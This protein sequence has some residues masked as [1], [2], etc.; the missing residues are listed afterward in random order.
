MNTAEN[1]TVRDELLQILSGFTP[2]GLKEMEFVHLMSRFD[3]KYIFHR[4]QL[5]SFLKKLQHDYRALTIDELPLFKYENLYFDTAALKSYHDH[6]NG[7][8]GRYKI[9]FRKY[10]DSDKCYFEVKQKTNKGLTEKARLSVPA[11]SK[12]LSSQH[13]DFVQQQLGNNTFQL[14]PQ[15][16]NNFSRITLVNEKGGERV[17]IDLMINF[18]NERAERSLNE[19]VIA[20][21]KQ[22]HASSLSVFKKL[23]QSHRIF[24]TSISKYCLGTLLT[25][26][27]I[28]YNRFKPK[29]TILNKICNVVD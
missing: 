27:G 8:S 10:S 29:L 1:K 11:F 20:E 13:L 4:S 2:I 18:K 14:V 9:R 17:T 23:M 19:L 28:K 15:I 3:M 7:K 16:S 6:H 25:H 24:P 12:E 26:P 22:H 5:P 21:V